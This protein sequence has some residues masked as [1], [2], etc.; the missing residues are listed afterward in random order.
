M[1]KTERKTIIALT[2]DDRC[3]HR[4]DRIIKLESGNI[5]AERHSASSSRP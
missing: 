5:V 2:H 1:L 3:F 4:A